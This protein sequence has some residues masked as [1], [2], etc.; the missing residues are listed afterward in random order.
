MG[1]VLAMLAE[2]GSGDDA[3][4]TS[5][6]DAHGISNRGRFGVRFRLVIYRLRRTDAT[7]WTVAPPPTSSGEEKVGPAAQAQATITIVNFSFGPDLV[8][9]PGA[10]VTVT[11]SDLAT[12]NVTADNGAFRTPDLARGASATFTAPS[13]PGRYAFGCTIHPQMRGVL[14]V[15]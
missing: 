10:T 5:R 11:N 13:T 1:L 8:V 12:H 14:V 3:N 9:R 7:S 2:D 4:T 15:G 6:Y